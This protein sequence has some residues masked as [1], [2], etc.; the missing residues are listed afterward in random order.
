MHQRT[1]VR[2]IVVVL[3]LILIDTITFA[4]AN[5]SG[6]WDVTMDPDFKGSPSTEPCQMK[7]QNRQLT[8]TCGAAGTAM[9]GNVNGENVA[10]KFISPGKW[11]A[12]WSGELDKPA[13]NI[14]GTWQ[15]TFAD[16]NTKRGSFTAQKQPN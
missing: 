9:V 6:R 16:G 7:Q 13:A 12:A 4:E 14:K 15:L 11:T 10:W 8:V 5:L 2:A 3:S 1:A